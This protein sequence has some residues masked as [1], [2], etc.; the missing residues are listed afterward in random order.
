MIIN[1]LKLLN[2][3]NH[4][5]RN[6]EFSRQINCFVGNNGV[7]KT[8]ILDALHYLS[9][10]KSFLGNT[11]LNNI[12]TEE[13]FFTIEGTIDDGEKENIIKIQQPKDTKK[14]IKRNDKSY[15]RMADHIGC[16]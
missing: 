15:E 8:N 11:D 5:E 6:F 7:G 13:D 16:L 4:V 14:I 1:N 2:F 3:K 9:M 12:R 10:G